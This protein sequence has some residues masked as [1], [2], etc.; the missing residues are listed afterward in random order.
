MNAYHHTDDV[1]LALAKKKNIAVV[2]PDPGLVKLRDQFVEHDINNVIAHAKEKLGID[3]A[4]EFVANYRKLYAKY[5]KLIAPVENQPDKLS[6]ILYQRGL[7]EARPEDRGRHAIAAWTAAG[8]HGS[9]HT[10]PGS[11][12]CRSRYR[13]V[14]SRILTRD[15]KFHWRAG[16]PRRRATRG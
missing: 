2:Q 16:F 1:G 8:I 3:D 14:A 5:A 11:R 10:S 7:R 4:A 6:D 9:R 12:G 13:R 15:R